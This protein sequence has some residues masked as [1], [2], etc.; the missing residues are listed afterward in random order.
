MPD[1]CGR[2]EGKQRSVEKIEKVREWGRE[3][4]REREKEIEWERMR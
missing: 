1:D 2:E 3:R 4:E